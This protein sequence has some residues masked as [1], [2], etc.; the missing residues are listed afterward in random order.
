MS[1]IDA[2]GKYFSRA[3]ERWLGWRA[4][5]SSGHRPLGLRRRD[6]FEHALRHCGDARQFRPPRRHY[7]FHRFSKM[8]AAARNG[9]FTFALLSGRT[10]SR[11]ADLR[12]A[13]H[14]R[15]RFLCDSGRT[16]RRLCDPD[17][18]PL[19]TGPI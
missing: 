2:S 11:V 6:F 8:V 18:R 4:L 10:C 12:K 14:G 19:P 1:A 17:L 15:G 7:F 16:R 13:E 3:S 5:G 9:F